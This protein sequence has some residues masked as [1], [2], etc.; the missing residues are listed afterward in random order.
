[1]N[2]SISTKRRSPLS[3]LFLF[4]TIIAGISCQKELSN[5]TSLPGGGGSGGSGG[6]AVFAL[7]PSGSNCSDAA[8]AGN[9]QVNITLAGDAK[10][11]VT[12]N[13]TKAGDWTYTTAPVNGF[14]FAGAGNFTTTGTQVIT[15]FATGKPAAAGY[16]DFNLN[17]GGGNC[18]LTVACNGGGSGGP[19]GEFYYK[20]TIDGVSYSQDVTDTNGYEA[21]SGMGGV[22]EVAFGG[23]INYGNPP[24]PAGKTEMG[25]SKGLMRND[26]SATTAQFKAFF[27]PGTYSYA[28][29]SFSQGDGVSIAWTDPTG[30]YWDTRDGTVDQAGSTFKIIST[31]DYPDA[32]GRTYIKVKMQFNCKLY[33]VNT[34]AVKTVTNG[35]IVVAFGK[36]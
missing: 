36:L 17:I 1:M 4:I 25:V 35:E 8:V 12:V 31:E 21:G 23:G 28:P 9:F 34:G 7:V 5:E 15:L 29:A 20:A 6:A 18:K 32:L 10:L 2:P 13:V 11:T 24:V 26:L 30:E 22:D 3:Y 27:A 16:F 33:N 14:V 19:L